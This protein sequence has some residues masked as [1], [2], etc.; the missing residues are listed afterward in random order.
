MSSTH[1]SAAHS[2]KAPWASCAAAPTYP[3]IALRIALRSFASPCRMQPHAIRAPSRVC[4]MWTAASRSDPTMASC[5]S[6]SPCSS[7]SAAPR[8]TSEVT[9]SPLRAAF[10]S[11][12][13]IRRSTRPLDAGSASRS[14]ASDA[15]GGAATAKRPYSRAHISE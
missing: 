6:G 5:C 10:E 14:A 3:F 15:A 13:S 8:W 1:S 9:A 2:T 11:K 4:M 12:I 7:R